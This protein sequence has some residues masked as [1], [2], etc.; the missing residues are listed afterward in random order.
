M[1]V[2]EVLEDYLFPCKK[3]KN[4]KTDSIF[5]AFSFSDSQIFISAEYN[6]DNMDFLML[7]ITSPFIKLHYKQ[8]MVHIGLIVFIWGSL[9]LT[10]P[11]KLRKSRKKWNSEKWAL[12]VIFFCT[13]LVSLVG[14]T[15]LSTRSILD[16]FHLCK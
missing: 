4:Y 1:I 3:L 2:L 11:P 14:T 6:M 13:Y 12:N 15:Y 5:L 16:Y 9:K 7:L 10:L 8:Y